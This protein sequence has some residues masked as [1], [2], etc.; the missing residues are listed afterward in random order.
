[1][2]QE[3]D[4]LKKIE[5]QIMA[6]IYGG[7][8]GQLEPE[9]IKEEK[10]QRA[11]AAAF[12]EESEAVHK[13]YERVIQRIQE[14]AINQ[15]VAF[16]GCE[17]PIPVESFVIKDDQLDRLIN[18][19]F[20]ETSSQKG[21]ELTGFQGEHLLA[22]YQIALKFYEDKRFEEAREV[23]ALLLALAPDVS[24]FWYG[25]GLAFEGLQRWE[26]SISA[27]NHAVVFDPDDFDAYLVLIRCA[28]QIN[29]FVPVTA[30]LEANKQN[31]AIA[32]QVNEA[33]GYMKSLK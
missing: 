12:L 33:L 26:D 24:S 13:G 22:I 1:M 25:L 23:F 30:L 8:P 21:V 31:P 15:E 9:N 2:D 17:E 29:D 6:S 27:L 28:S 4:D 19:G 3:Q 11:N 5:R 16:E 32:D 7:H 10:N 18:H 20:A 14:L